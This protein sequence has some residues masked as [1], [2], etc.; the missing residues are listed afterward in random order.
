MAQSRSAELARVTVMA[1]YARPYIQ[2]FP[3]HIMIGCTYRRYTPVS[4]PNDLAGSKCLKFN[5]RHNM[6]SAPETT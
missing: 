3:V 4:T 2:T 5:F 6:T 1:R